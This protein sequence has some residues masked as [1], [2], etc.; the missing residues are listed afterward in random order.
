MISIADRSIS[1]WYSTQRL[2]LTQCQFVVELWSSKN[3][4]VNY[5]PVDAR[6]PHVCA[7]LSLAVAMFVVFVS[8]CVIT[9]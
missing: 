6:L 3:I 5:I 7:L 2:L 1:Y 9:H 4:D 8:M